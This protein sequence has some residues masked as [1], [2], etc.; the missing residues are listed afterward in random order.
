[1]DFDDIKKL[2][3]DDLIHA[4][5][6]QMDKE[7]LYNKALA[8]KN[9]DAGKYHLYIIMSANKGYQLAKDEFYD[10]YYEQLSVES[11]KPSL[12]QSNVEIKDLLPEQSNVE[13]K[14]LLPEQ[15]NVEIKDL[16]PIALYKAKKFYEHTKDYS[17][18]SLL[19]G[20]LMSIDKDYVKA[21]ELY[22]LAIEQDPT[23][24]FAYWNIALMY[25]HG[26]GVDQDIKMSRKYY[27]LSEANKSPYCVYKTACSVLEQYGGRKWKQ[28]ENRFK[29]CIAMGPSYE[30]KSITKL[31][32]IY[33]MRYTKNRLQKQIV[34]YFIEIERTD[35]L[36]DLYN[37]DD[38]AI[39]IMKQ[40]G[41]LKKESAAI[42]MGLYFK[43]LMTEPS[44]VS[45]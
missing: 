1:M 30:E 12:M 23:N 41:L 18:S 10:Y 40:N 29:E 13:I 19:M 5:I 21:K 22:D 17:Y 6:V 3:T 8:L 36:K 43:S 20:E 2:P 26:L 34:D 42:D 9:S 32:E 7:E 39:N 45:E 11:C 38:N 33:N 15:S 4:L 24:T 25:D 14:D 35:K 28:A 44:N 37:Y 27:R 31:I 16:Y